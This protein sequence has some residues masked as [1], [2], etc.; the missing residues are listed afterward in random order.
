MALTAY[1][2]EAAATAEHAAEGGGIHVVLKAETIGHFLGLPITNSLLL[3]WITMA[4]LVIFA[5]LLRRKLALIPGKL[6]AGVEWLFEAVLNYMS[7]TLENEKLARKFFPLVMTIFLLVL[8]GNELAFVPGVGSIGVGGEHGLVPLLRAPAADLNFTLALAFISF[9]TIEITSIAVLGFLKYGG[10]YVN[11]KSPVG[12]AVGLIEIVSNLGRVISFSFRL[13]GNI[14]AGEVMIVV[15][16]FF[17]AY[18]L[19]VPLMAFEVFVG[20]IQAVV[21]AML[22]LFFIKLAIMDPHESH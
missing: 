5:F 11:F 13:F 16:A 22:T 18:L 12:F 19:P 10:K 14:F 7:E 8:L 9:F 15:A 17:L 2:A 4:V 21:F 3:T 20:F 6:Q 1:A